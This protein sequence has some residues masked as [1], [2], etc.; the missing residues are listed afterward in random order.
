MKAIEFV[1]YGPP[2]EVCRC[3]EVNDAPSPSSGQ[4]TI[5]VEAAAINPADLLILE[6]RYPGPQPPA[7]QGIEG[8]GKVVAIGEDVTGFSI[9][10]QA[11]LLSRDNWVEKQTIPASQ[12]IKIPNKMD[13]LQ[14][15]QIKA[16]PP[17]AMLML[18]NYEDLK[19][20][21]WV[22]QNA[23]NSAVGMHVIK[24]AQARGIRTVNVVRRKDLFNILQEHGADVVVLEGSDLGSRV[25]DKIGD[26][27]MPLAIDAIGGAS[28]MHLADCLSNGGTVVNYGFLSGDPCMLTPTHTIVRQIKLVG[29]WLGPSL[30]NS[31]NDV[32]KTTY[33]ELAQMFIEG[34]LYSPVEATY[35]LDQVKI[36]LKHAAREGRSGKIIFT[37]NG[38]IS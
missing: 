19:E 12:A 38:P 20:G 4:I 13:I 34:L 36:A 14:A 24:L 31:S 6:G 9:G 15:A 17:S 11:M 5:A 3:I 35:T 7:R 27:R 23:A 16:N 2:H 29:F 10:D 32:I 28:C 8:A 18:T 33:A 22:I 25:R 1:Q 26:A 37:P 21:D 30:F